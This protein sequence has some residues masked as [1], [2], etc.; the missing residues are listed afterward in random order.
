MVRQAVRYRSVWSP[1]GC[2]KFAIRGSAG[3]H[4]SQVEGKI[5]VHISSSTC[6]LLLL[7]YYLMAQRTSFRIDELA[8]TGVKGTVT[9]SREREV[10]FKHSW[11]AEFI[12]HGLVLTI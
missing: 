11:Q 5:A 4:A 2:L 7:Y 9:S 8:L 12:H 10:E 6:H 1:N 3:R